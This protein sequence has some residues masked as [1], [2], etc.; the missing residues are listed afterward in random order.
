[1]SSADQ[2]RSTT[3]TPSS[4][5]R[6]GSCTPPPVNREKWDHC[7]TP[8]APEAPYDLLACYGWHLGSQA[9]PIPYQQDLFIY[10]S[11]QCYPI[12]HNHLANDYVAEQPPGAYPW[13]RIEVCGSTPEPVLDQ[14]AGHAPHGL[15]SAIT[16]RP[17]HDRHEDVNYRLLY[18]DLPPYP[19]NHY[20]MHGS[21]TAYNQSYF[22][23][24]YQEAHEHPENWETSSEYA[25]ALLPVLLLTLPNENLQPR[26][27]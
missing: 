21:G 14:I 23:P 11:H 6:E 9:L 8:G 2:S 25:E 26:D 22:G 5:E 18:E 10:Q 16:L 15:G 27:F 24:S 20:L 7:R 4:S 17:H 3:P 1:M 13:S 12:S 19:N